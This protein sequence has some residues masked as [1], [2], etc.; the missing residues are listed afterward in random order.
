MITSQAKFVASKQDFLAQWQ[1]TDL[2]LQ[3][4]MARFPAEGDSFKWTL[5]L[6][7]VT[8]CN[9]RIIPNILEG[10][11]IGGLDFIMANAKS[12]YAKLEKM[13][14]NINFELS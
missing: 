3:G 11:W 14:K 13:V 12:Y 2:A 7:A 6:V 9:G 10:G 4:P 8:V 5:L 1:S